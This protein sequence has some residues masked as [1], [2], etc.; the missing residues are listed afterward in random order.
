MSDT[1]DGTEDQGT[2]GESLGADINTT[3]PLVA[4]AAPLAIAPP[5]PPSGLADPD[6]RKRRLEAQRRKDNESVAWAYRLNTGKKR[7]PKKGI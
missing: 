6:E 7:K 3:A 5:P 1:N 4:V 2:N